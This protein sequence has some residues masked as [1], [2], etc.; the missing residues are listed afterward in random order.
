MP[1]SFVWHEGE[2]KFTLSLHSSFSQLVK[3]SR[4]LDEGID[5]LATI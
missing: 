5:D 1:G 2:E 3:T 4:R